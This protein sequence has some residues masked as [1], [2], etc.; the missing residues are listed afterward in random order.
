MQSILLVHDTGLFRALAETIP[1]RTNCRVLLASNGTEALA[2]ARMEKPDIVFL[3]ADLTGMTGVDIC[4]VLKADPLFGRTP[5]VL[6]GTD[7]KSRDEGHRAGASDFLWKPIDEIGFF[8][9]FRRLLQ[10][11]PREAARAPFG[12]SVTFW[13]DGIQYE[14]TIRDLA[15]GGFFVRTPITQPIGARIEVAFDIPGRKAGRTVV[16]EAI[17]VRVGQDSDR[18]LGC[19]FFRVAASSR[20]NLEECLRSLSLGEAAAS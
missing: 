17:V 4:R 13:R 18:G 14:G 10:I 5:V 15:K 19:R 1:R 8:D 9:T 2:V 20:V 12:F 6:I 3:D 7:A 11:L 16:A